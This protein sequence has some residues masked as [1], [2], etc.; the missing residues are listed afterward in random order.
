MSD[1]KFPG[2]V[3]VVDVQDLPDG[4]A[5]VTFEA[6][7]EFKEGF[8]KHYG[9]KRWSNKKFN[10]FLQ[11]AIS[12]MANLIRIENSLDKETKKFFKNS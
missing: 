3:K 2:T 5:K 10:S 11:E 6:D 8:K 4:S 9:L 1:F 7:D 12:T